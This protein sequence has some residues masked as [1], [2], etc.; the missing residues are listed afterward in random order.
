M[1]LSNVGFGTLPDSVDHA[2]TGGE[3]FAGSPFQTTKSPKEG[4]DGTAGNTS[5]SG[6]SWRELLT[7]S[8]GLET[9]VSTDAI[10]TEDL[11]PEP[12]AFADFLRLFLVSFAS[13]KLSLSRSA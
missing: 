9:E 6:C 12:F 1:S 8:T 5:F 7:L 13:M 2:G 3:G 4:P 10:D 11:V